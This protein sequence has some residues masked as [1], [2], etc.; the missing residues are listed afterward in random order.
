MAKKTNFEVNG[1]KYYRVTRTVG[2]KAD[3]T[4]IRKTFYGSGIN[5]ANEKADAYINDIKNGLVNNYEYAIF[6][7][8]MTVWLFDFLHK[9]SKIKPST[10]QRYE[11]IYRKYIKDSD[12]AGLNLKDCNTIKLQKF[13]NDLSVTYSYSQLRYLC[14]VMRNFLNWCIDSGYILKN[15]CLKIEIKGNKSEI[16]KRKKENKIEI[17]SEDEIQKIKEYI[18]GTEFEL[19]FLLDL[20]TGLREGE[21]LALIWND[22]DLKNKTLKIEKSVKEVYVYDDENS[23]HIETIV[24]VPKTMTSFRTIPIP[25]SVIGI[26][27]NVKNKNGIIFH[28]ENMNYL[29]AKNVSYKW[30]KIL[31]NC[32]I[33]HKKFHSIRHTYASTL[34]KNGVDIQTVAELMG[35]SAIAITQIYLHS[36]N[37]QKYNA[38]NK[39][40]YL[41]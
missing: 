10:F 30:K 34:L 38:V 20:S 40:N 9:S 3:G 2:K 17:L 13:F 11:G 26:L 27:N 41:F 7:E 24:Q 16:I 29:K 1:K 18:K 39:L 15:P 36:T 32:D 14:D 28:D 12:I 21:L 25:S 33:P 22:V 37:E 4:P 6:S 19:L 23:R 35:H 5:E 8:L 31:K